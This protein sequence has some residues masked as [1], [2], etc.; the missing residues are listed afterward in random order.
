MICVPI[1][2]K[3]LAKGKAEIV[4]QVSLVIHR[5]TKMSYYGGPLFIVY[6]IPRV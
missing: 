2:N 4:E 6:S 5:A 3:L 1:S